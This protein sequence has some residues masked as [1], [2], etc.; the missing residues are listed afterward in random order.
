MNIVLSSIPHLHTSC[1]LSSTSA[2]VAIFM[3][4]APNHHLGTTQLDFK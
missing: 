4:S 1:T 3:I 2:Q